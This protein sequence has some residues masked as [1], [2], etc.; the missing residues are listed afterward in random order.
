MNYMKQVAEM[1]GVELGEKFDIEVGNGFTLDDY[2]ITEDG[3]TSKDGESRD[4]SSLTNL[5][6]SKYTIKKKP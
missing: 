4:T 5:L 6:T 3:L 1:L 2:Y